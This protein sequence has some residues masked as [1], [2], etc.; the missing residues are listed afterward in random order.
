M[1]PIG[2]QVAA[3]PPSEAAGSAAGSGVAAP[4]SEAA[5]SAAGSGVG[6]VGDVGKFAKSMP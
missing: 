3:A 5:G 2:S 1:Q 4:P 6:G